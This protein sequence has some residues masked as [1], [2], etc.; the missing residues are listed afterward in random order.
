M[1]RALHLALFLP[2]LAGAPGCGF[3][4][5]A[6]A[7]SYE[8]ERR[9]ISE[10]LDPV[11]ERVDRLESEEK[12][13]GLGALFSELLPWLVAGYGIRIAGLNGFARKAKAAAG[14]RRK[15]SA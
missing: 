11:R 1:I 2:V 6:L 9:A 12:G 10:A 5:G 14:S 15:G 7:P 8:P 3:A 4:R 13:A